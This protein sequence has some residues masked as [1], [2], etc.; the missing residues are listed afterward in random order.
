MYHISQEDRASQALQGTA[1]GSS[2]FGLEAEG[3]T[4]GKPEPDAFTGVSAG[5][6]RQ[7][8]VTSL[9]L[10]SLNNP[11]GLYAGIWSWHDLRPGKS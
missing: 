9:G 11:H 4:E 5:K 6:A 2:R 1:W 10:A 8:K 7:G 3:R